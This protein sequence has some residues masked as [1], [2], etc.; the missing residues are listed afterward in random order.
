MVYS[1]FVWY[2]GIIAEVISYSY[3][4]KYNQAKNNMGIAER[5]CSKAYE[6]IASA[7]CMISVL[8]CKCG[9]EGVSDLWPDPRGDFSLSISLW[10]IAYLWYKVTQATAIKQVYFSLSHHIMCLEDRNWV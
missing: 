7:L 9:M 6:Q 8:K 3:V 10:V 2:A 1:S 5:K 4:A